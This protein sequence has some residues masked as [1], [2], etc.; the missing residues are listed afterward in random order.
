MFF[1][2]VF[3]ESYVNMY[4]CLSSSVFSDMAWRD[5]F[6]SCLCFS[7]LF[8]SPLLYFLFDVHFCFLLDSTRRFDCPCL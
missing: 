6:L 5:I 3:K 7:V 1:R 8:L 2:R 4:I